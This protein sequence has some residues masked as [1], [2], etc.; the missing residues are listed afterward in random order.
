MTESQLVL[1]SQKFMQDQS[2]V[3]D[4]I[5]LKSRIQNELKQKIT[6]SQISNLR[7]GIQD[8]SI[9]NQIVNLANVEL[10]QRDKTEQNLFAISMASSVILKEL[11]FNRFNTPNGHLEIY[12]E[13][14]KK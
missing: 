11:D 3:N 7:Q 4:M 13:L 2:V 6:D 5:T 1:L 12:N 9:I 8:P 10:A 14:Q